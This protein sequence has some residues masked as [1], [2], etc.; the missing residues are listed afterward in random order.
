MLRSCSVVS[1]CCS[2]RRVS[3]A[4][5]P[6]QGWRPLRGANYGLGSS[7]PLAMMSHRNGW[8]GSRTDRADRSAA[9]QKFET[10]LIDLPG[11]T[12]KVTILL[13]FETMMAEKPQ[14]RDLMCIF[15]QKFDKIR[16]FYSSRTKNARLDRTELKPL[17]SIQ[18]WNK[19]LNKL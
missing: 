17:F 18:K 15:R 14:K 4:R 13:G 7:A 19:S 5:P 2:Q 11:P 12:T 1:R 10:D 8:L 16:G 3:E 6:P 9:V